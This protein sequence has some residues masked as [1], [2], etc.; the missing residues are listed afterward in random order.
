M[1]KRAYFGNLRLWSHARDNTRQSDR[2][3][4]VSVALGVDQDRA[5]HDPASVNRTGGR[6]VRT[7]G[8]PHPTYLT[9]EAWTAVKDAAHDAI[10]ARMGYGFPLVWCADDS[11]DSVV[12]SGAGTSIMAVGT[13]IFAANDY[14][15]FHRP[16][17]GTDR[18]SLH[19]FG[20]ARVATPGSAGVA[21][22]FA[23]DPAT[24]DYAPEPGDKMCRV[25]HL[26]TPLYCQA[27]RPIGV[28][29]GQRGD[30]YN[31][32]IVWPFV[33]SPTTTIHRVSVSLE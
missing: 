2:G 8:A 14:V 13:P 4:P 22:I 16:S 12:Q 18:A 29:G 15:F 1:A 11:L 5:I 20:W 24:A 33:G 3:N 32:S 21:I 26:W 6:E 23:T 19:Y 28:Q 10:E 27:I 25:S 30:Y 9:Q 17:T 31:P 7:Y